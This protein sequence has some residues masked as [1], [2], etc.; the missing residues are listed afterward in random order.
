M[1]RSKTPARGICR[2]LIAFTTVPS[3]VACP[4][5]DDCCARAPQDTCESNIRINARYPMFCLFLFRKQLIKGLSILA[6]RAKQLAEN[7]QQVLIWIKWFRVPPSFP[8]L[9]PFLCTT[10]QHI[11]L[12]LR[13]ILLSFV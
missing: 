4:E 8:P 1:L 7:P 9:P 5:P 12:V 6:T 13:R 2:A 10:I 11:L 3:T